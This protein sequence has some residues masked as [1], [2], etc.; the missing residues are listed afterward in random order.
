MPVSEGR[1][2][3]LRLFEAGAATVAIALAVVGLALYPLTTAPAV[4]ALVRAVGSERLTGLGTDATL[5]AADAVRV[6]VLDPDAPSLPEQIDGEPAFD[7]FAVSHL[8]DVR[9]VMVPARWATLAL[10]LLAGVWAGIRCRAADGRRV[11]AASA[12][13][14]GWL[15]LAGAGLAVLAGVA[16]F[17]ML[18]SRFHGLFFEAGTWMFPADALLIRVFPLPFWQSAAA[19]WGALVLICAAALFLAA[20]RLRFTR[21]TY[22][23]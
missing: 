3:P 9:K 11:V 14:A 15:L 10:A 8:V 21:G 20:R 1:L 22:G 19:L 13:S 4:G 2:R 6:F 18:F 16:D 23:V 5:E 17:D 12:R 7:S